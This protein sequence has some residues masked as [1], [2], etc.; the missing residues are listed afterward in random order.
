[1]RI[2]IALAVVAALAPAAARAQ[3]TTMSVGHLVAD[4]M[5]LDTCMKWGDAALRQAGLKVVAPSVS[6]VWGVTADGK[7]TATIYCAESRGVIFVA[8]SGASIEGTRPVLARLT[9]Q[10]KKQR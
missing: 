2:A 5:A 3:S 7:N 4:R 10:L 8:V 1:M 9:E 6:A